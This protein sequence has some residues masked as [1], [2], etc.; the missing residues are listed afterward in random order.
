LIGSFRPQISSEGNKDLTKLIQWENRL[1]IS[2]VDREKE[3]GDSIGIPV[4]LDRIDEAKAQ[5]TE[6]LNPLLEKNVRAGTLTFL[7][8]EKGEPTEVE[9]K[10]S[11]VVISTLTMNFSRNDQAIS[12]ALRNR[13]VTIAV[14]VPKLNKSKRVEIAKSTIRNF[15]SHKHAADQKHSEQMKHLKRPVSKIKKFAEAIADSFSDNFFV[16]DVAF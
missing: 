15:N 14:E 16:L 4:I 13:F 11:F 12:L 9:V 5:V 3:T 6:R 8:P 10:E 1:L 7:V 2:V